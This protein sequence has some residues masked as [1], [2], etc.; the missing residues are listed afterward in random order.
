MRVKQVFHAFAVLAKFERNV[1][2][3]RG[4]PWLEAAIR[5]N[6]VGLYVRTAWYERERFGSLRKRPRACDEAFPNEGG[7]AVLSQ[8]HIEPGANPDSEL[9]AW[10]DHVVDAGEDAV[11]I[12]I[13][14]ASIT[15]P[16]GVNGYEISPET[17][18]S[19]GWYWPWN[20]AGFRCLDRDRHLD[21]ATLFKVAYLAALRFQHTGQYRLHK[22]M[23]LCNVCFSL[24]KAH[25]LGS[26]IVPALLGMAEDATEG[27][28]PSYMPNFRNLLLA[29]FPE[30]EARFLSNFF[31]SATRQRGV[32][33]LYPEVILRAADQPKLSLLPSLISELGQ[34]AGEFR[35]ET[36]HVSLGKLAE[37]WG[38]FPHVVSV[39]EKRRTSHGQ[40]SGV[41]PQ[42]SLVVAA[43]KERPPSL[44]VGW[45]LAPRE[46]DRRG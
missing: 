5:A 44:H 20:R 18:G 6:C 29:N 33:P 25:E 14:I 2:S 34:V 21:A 24:L 37:L 1:R 45:D 43:G 46:P 17:I 8:P 12:A 42:P 19:E 35:P 23:P 22:G 28:D 27:W 16:G 40:F 9:E 26:A 15:Q 39:M 3:E 30:D 13:A 38:E 4:H 36:V 32:I 11:D 10:I 41:A 31:M 7:G